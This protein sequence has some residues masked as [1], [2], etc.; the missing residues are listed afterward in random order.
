MGG[1]VSGSLVVRVLGGWTAS[2]GVLLGVSLLTG[3]GGGSGGSSSPLSHYSSSAGWK[4]GTFNEASQYANKCAIPRV[5]KS[6]VSGDPYP[7]TQGTT[8]DENNFLRSWSND[9]YL[10]Y[11]EIVD[12]NPASYSDPL[13]YFALLKTTAKT[14]TGADKDKFHFTYNTDDWESLSGSGVVY[15][16]G[17]EF[18]FIANTPPRE[19]RVAYTQPDSPAALAN[20]PRGAKILKVDGVDLV[21]DG[22]SDGVDTLNNGLFPSAVGEAH[23]FEIM[24]PGASSS[25][26]ITL[27]SA[28]V[29][30]VPVQNVKVIQTDSG[31]VGYL[32]FNDHIATAE[33]GLVDAV[34]QLQGESISDLVL[35]IRYNGGG[36]LAIASELAY[37]IAGSA[38]TQGQVFEQLQFN[39]KYPTKD[40]IT[41]QTLNPDPFYNIA[42]GFSMSY[43]TALPELNLARV[44]VLTSGDTCSASEALINGLRGVGVQVIQIG[45]TT[46]GKPYGFYPEPNCGTTYFSIQF[47][48]VNAQNFGD[49]SDGFIPSASDDSKTHILGCSLGDDFNHALGDESEA[50]LAAALYYRDNNACPSVSLGSGLS[51]KVQANQLQDGSLIKPEALQNAWGKR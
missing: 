34:S 51:G 10:W 16:Y 31:K 41:G 21:N 17:M 3:C 36:Y 7:D 45:R 37:M 4:Q 23:V 8:T 49:F 48:G 38:R 6:P 43:G 11:N 2:L 20:I 47:R 40:P 33:K 18:S 46:C 42:L 9:T 50:R 25:R 19:L 30:T 26:E 1:K 13:N 39:D 29:T 14:D 24:E 28:S 32:T 15:G 44:F 22:S 35:D 27:Q 5:G 12:R